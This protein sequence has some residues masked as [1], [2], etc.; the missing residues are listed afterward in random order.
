[1]YEVSEAEASFLGVGLE[2]NDTPKAEPTSVSSES[3]AKKP[4]AKKNSVFCLV[5]EPEKVGDGINAYD[6]FSVFLS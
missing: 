1:M 2:S 3:V 5:R 6:F 4:K